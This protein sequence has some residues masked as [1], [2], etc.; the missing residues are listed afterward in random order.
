MSQNINHYVSFFREFRRTFH[1]TGAILP[2][3]QQLT[4]A[5]LKPFINRGRPSRVLEVGPGTGAVTQQIVKHLRKGD[6]FDIVELNDSFVEILRKRF[7]SEPAF[8]KFAGQSTVHHLPI[9]EFVAAEPYDF[10]MCGL[11]FNNLPPR[12]V[13]DIFKH[14]T[15]LLAPAGVLSFFE[16]LWIRRMSSLLSSRP[17]RRRL[18]RVGCI[19]S[20]YL[21]RYAF[22]HDTAYVNFPPAVVHHL[23]LNLDAQSSPSNEIVA[24]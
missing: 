3:G 7:V 15:Q 11:P 19:L 14:F 21:D 5:T 23:R 20:W 2:S 22:H 9:Q 6:V 4:K 12:L 1:T 18:A 24:A 13:K 10:I 8:Q 16:Y 17:E